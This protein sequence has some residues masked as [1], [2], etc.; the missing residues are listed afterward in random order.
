MFML[1]HGSCACLLCCPC[2]KQRPFTAGVYEALPLLPTVRTARQRN[3]FKSMDSIYNGKLLY[4][5]LLK[6]R[7]LN[8]AP[9]R[10]VV[11]AEITPMR[12]RN[13]NDG[14]FTGFVAATLVN[15]MS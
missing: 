13:Y 2:T 9:I 3:V 1:L 7:M 4:D 6:Q 15:K 5:T 14:K 8:P 10:Y 11:I 12:K